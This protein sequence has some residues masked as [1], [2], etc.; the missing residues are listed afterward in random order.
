MFGFYARSPKPPQTDVPCG[1]ATP[2]YKAYQGVLIAA[3]TGGDHF[4]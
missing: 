4:S 3:E 1:Q 2:P